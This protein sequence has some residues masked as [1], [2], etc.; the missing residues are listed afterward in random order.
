MVRHGE[1]AWNAEKRIQGQQDIA[2]N[3]TGL[4]QAKAAA[5]GFSGL[6]VTALYSSDLLRARQTAE[7][8]GETLGLVPQLL[9]EFRERRYGLFE[10]LT[11][12]EARLAHPDDYAC[13]ERR[14]ATRSLP[15]GGE[16]LQ[17][18]YQRVT[19]RLQALAKRHDGETLVVVTHGGVLDVVNRFVRGGALE[20]PRDFI[21][22]NAGLNWLI[23]QQGQWRI[24]AWAVTAHLTAV[25]QDELP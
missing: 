5:A 1:T 3:E 17:A 9:P 25:G 6:P 4:A 18:L 23:R 21:I 14:E 12:S 22:P 24:E 16:S 10:C 20:T 13:F 11:Y 2:L 19:E 8:L 7:C 15:G